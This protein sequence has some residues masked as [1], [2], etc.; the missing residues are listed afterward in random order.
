MAANFSYSWLLHFFFSIIATAPLRSLLAETRAHF[1]SHGSAV[2][3]RL[4]SGALQGATTASTSV[5]TEGVQALQQSSSAQAALEVSG[6]IMA[7]VI[8]QKEEQGQVC[9]LC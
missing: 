8:A 2:L 1:R 6:W 4:T 3:D 7:D 5:S 9:L